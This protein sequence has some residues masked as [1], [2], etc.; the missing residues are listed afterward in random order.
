MV[1]WGSRPS[2]KG[3]YT[4]HPRWCRMF[5]INSLSQMAW[6]PPILECICCVGHFLWTS[7]TGWK[8]SPKITTEI[9][10]GEI[11]PCKS[12]D[13]CFSRGLFHPQFQGTIFFMVFDFQGMCFR[14]HVFLVPKVDTFIWQGFVYVPCWGGF[15]NIIPKRSKRSLIWLWWYF[16]QNHPKASK[17]YHPKPSIKVINITPTK[18]SKKGGAI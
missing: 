6:K 15:K 11:M 2:F 7:W 17:K 12:K 5:S 16:P 3:F 9:F 14:N 4:I 18:P 10:E 8:N 1:V 13:Y